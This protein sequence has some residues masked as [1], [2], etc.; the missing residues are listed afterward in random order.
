MKP[1]ERTLEFRCGCWNRKSRPTKAMCDKCYELY[2]D[3]TYAYLR[4]QSM[5]MDR[6]FE[7]MDGARGKLKL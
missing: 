5:A 6:V 7:A 2:E 1:V 3:P 4:G